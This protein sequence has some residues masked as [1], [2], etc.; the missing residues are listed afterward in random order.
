MPFVSRQ[1]ILL[2]STVK[3]EFDA[4][5]KEKKLDKG[6]FLAVK[7][8]TA[9]CKRSSFL[10][11]GLQTTTNSTQTWCRSNRVF[12]CKS[13][14]LLTVR[15]CPQPCL[16]GNLLCRVDWLSLTGIAGCGCAIV[17]IIEIATFPRCSSSRHG[18]SGSAPRRA[19]PCQHRRLQTYSDTERAA[20]ASRTAPSSALDPAEH[21]VEDNNQ[22][23]LAKTSTSFDTG[24]RQQHAD[25]NPAISNLR[26]Q[27]FLF[28][29]SWEMD[30]HTRRRRVRA[31]LIRALGTDHERERRDFGGNAG[32]A[33]RGGHPAGPLPRPRVRQLQHGVP[34]VASA[35]VCAALKGSADRSG[36]TG[37]TEVA[38]TARIGQHSGIS[39]SGIKQQLPSDH[40]ALIFSTFSLKTLSPDS[41]AQHARD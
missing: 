7:M 5:E 6:H 36:P 30:A 3:S 39:V 13:S 37:T 11:R 34:A 14:S 32:A 28:P 26:R 23:T 21:P 17:P 31:L 18:S 16:T 29:K 12:C 41:H 15:I 9:A 4:M 24:F 20:L 1:Q 27:R 40:P 19:G 33:R 10:G 38:T 35:P 2:A 25:S 8:Q 22:L